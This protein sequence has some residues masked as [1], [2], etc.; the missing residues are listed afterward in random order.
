MSTEAK[1]SK[2]R[3]IGVASLAFAGM[4]GLSVYG[5]SRKPEAAPEAS[6]ARPSLVYKIPVSMS[7][8]SKG[9]EDALVTLVQWCDLPDPRC[10]AI[11]PALQALLKKHPKDL[12][13][14]FRHYLEPKREGSSQAHQLAR[15]AHERGGKFWEA[16]ELLLSQKG[17][18]PF[19]QLEGIAVQ[20]GLDWPQAKAAIEGGNFGGAVV[21]DRMF[22]SMFDVASTPA[23]FAN[24]RPLQGPVTEDALTKLVEEELA[25]AKDSIGQGVQRA[26]LYAELT[27]NG[28]W[29]PAKPPSAQ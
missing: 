5:L 21:A 6:P 18:V 23:L 1:M 20:L 22:A 27:K 17:D 29:S 25:R 24:G 3:V 12:R 2:A 11:E 26:N 28:T 7:Q 14:V 4:F 19:E 13:L 8:P 15:L 9:P 16:R 10:A